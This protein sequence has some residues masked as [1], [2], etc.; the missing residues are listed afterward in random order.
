M[1]FTDLV[2]RTD[3]VT[4]DSTS[5]VEESRIKVWREDS[6][7]GVV[8]NVSSNT[9]EDWSFDV[10]IVNS[11]TDFVLVEVNNSD[12]VVGFIAFEL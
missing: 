12:E 4:S 9:F 3:V 2:C 10:D 5:I 6:D 8:F 1:L 11:C 7:G